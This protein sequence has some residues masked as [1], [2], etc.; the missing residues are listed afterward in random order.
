ML[1]KTNKQHGGAEME[2]KK[3]C[4][5]CNEVIEADEETCQCD[6]CEAEVHVECGGFGSFVGIETWGCDNCRKWD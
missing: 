1:I 4:S 2:D 6:A 3:I 5:V